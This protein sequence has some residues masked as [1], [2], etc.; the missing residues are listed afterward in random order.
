MQ[1]RFIVIAL[2]G[3]LFVPAVGF[4]QFKQGD[5]ELTLS[6]TGN[7]PSDIGSFSFGASGSIGLF[8]A[9]QLELGLRQSGAYTD[10]NGSSWN[11]STAIFL[12]YH[13]D[14]GAFQPF[15]G[16]NGGYVYGEGVHDTWELAPEGGVKFFVN[17]TTFIFAM[18]Q[19]QFF[20]EPGS[21]IQDEFS[22]GQFVYSL[23]I[24]FKF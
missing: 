14:F 22:H 21:N 5:W 1:Q 8:L 7:T 12:D 19:Y 24:G 2:L 11:G 13:F 3:A 18:V 17:G 10:V 16:V 4:A 23:G 20:L 6:G 15:I 9:D